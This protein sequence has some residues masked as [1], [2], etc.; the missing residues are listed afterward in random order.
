MSD[1]YSILKINN[2]SVVNN[3]ATGNYGGVYAKGYLV[4][5]SYTSISGNVNYG[6]YG[7]GVYSQN[8][9]IEISGSVYVFG[10]RT[11]VSRQSDVSFGKVLNQAFKF[12]TEK[13]QYGLIG[14]RTQCAENMV[15]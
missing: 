14:V 13:P 5:Q 3:K 8:D 11:C 12:G 4:L 10:N 1:E 9:S 7:G 2:S 6:E 15:L